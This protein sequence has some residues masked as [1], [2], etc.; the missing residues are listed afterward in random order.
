M[1]NKSILMYSTLILL[2]LISSCGIH[3]PPEPTNSPPDPIIPIGNNQDEPYSPNLE[4]KRVRIMDSHLSITICFDLPSNRNDWIMGRLA[5]DV[6]LS[7]DTH[8]VPLTNFSLVSMDN[9]P[10][11]AVQTRC[12][13]SE[14]DIPDGFN[15]KQVTLTVERIAAPIPHNLDWDPVIQKIEEIA[16]KLVWEPMFDQPGPGFSIEETPPGMTALEA[17]D[18]IIGIIEPVVIGPWSI[19]V[20]TDFQ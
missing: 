18:I 4:I 12:E 1:K 20:E 2:L 5:G 3:P 8:T 19:R 11:S 14:I 15:F 10:G 17:H 7:D 9:K 16:P 6:N 13:Q